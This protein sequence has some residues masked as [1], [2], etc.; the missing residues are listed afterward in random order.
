MLNVQSQR[1][2]LLEHVL[3]IAMPP[4]VPFDLGDGRDIAGTEGGDL[5]GH[6]DQDQPQNQQSAAKARPREPHVDSLRLVIPPDG[7][8]SCP[9]VADGI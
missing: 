7:I 5:G 4:V 6:E 1:C 8:P 3:N 9:Q 2:S